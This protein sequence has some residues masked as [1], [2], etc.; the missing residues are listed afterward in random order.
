M[1]LP[2][3]LKLPKPGFFTKFLK[4]LNINRISRLGMHYR[5]IKPHLAPK[6]DKEI[7]ET[8]YFTK[9]FDSYYSKAI[10][11]VNFRGFFYALLYA[12]LIVN[13][14]MLIPWLAWIVPYIRLTGSLVSTS[15]I[16]F[17]IFIVTVRI[18]LYLELLNECL[19]HLVVVYHNNPK[20]D[21]KKMLDDVSKTI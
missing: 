20:R 6:S 1:K 7:V 21:S 14:I 4:I 2:K 9:R 3:S 11:L 16:V 18:N 19:T 17:I 12:S 5:A 8:E 13:V 15:I 10:T